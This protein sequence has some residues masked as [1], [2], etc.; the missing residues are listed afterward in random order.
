MI[1]PA[2]FGVPVC[3]GPN[4]ANFKSTVDGLLA[5]NA[6][7]VVA[8]AEELSAFLSQMLSDLSQRD[9]IGSRAQSF[10]LEHRGA[11]AQTVDLIQGLLSNCGEESAKQA[12]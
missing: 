10:V 3:F 4:T 12:A 11:T 6:A 5:A 2:A 1:E 9:A 7:T 8:D